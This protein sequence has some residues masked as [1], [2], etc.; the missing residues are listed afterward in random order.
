[1]AGQESL[2]DW[3][4]DLPCACEGF[5]VAALVE[6]FLLFAIVMGWVTTLSL[7]TLLVMSFLSVVMTLSF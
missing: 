2:L 5:V 6:L 7:P 3:H 1:M 4:R